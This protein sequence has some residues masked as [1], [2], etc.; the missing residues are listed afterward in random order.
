[1]QSKSMLVM[2]SI[3][4]VVA[5]IALRS[6]LAPIRAIADREVKTPISFSEIVAG[7]RSRIENIR[8]GS[9]TIRGTKFD[10]RDQ[11][12]YQ[13]PVEIFC[14][15]ADGF[16]KV[17][18]ERSE[19]EVWIDRSDSPNPRFAKPMS[20]RYFRTKDVSGIYFG[21]ANQTQL[22]SADERH[23]PFVKPLDPRCV[24]LLFETDQELSLD[25]ALRILSSHKPNNSFVESDG[26][27]CLNG[28]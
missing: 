23:N 4:L 28:S 5:A 6:N 8:S 26:T 27:V 17:R 18:F 3:L 21:D 19:F 1:M 25:N 24:G 14:A 7:V 2:A 13:G 22:R 12:S 11:E 15:F 16:E 9:V 20:T 10:V